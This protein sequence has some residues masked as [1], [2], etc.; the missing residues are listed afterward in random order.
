MLFD[1][2]YILNITIILILIF[3]SPTY[4][5]HKS[6]ENDKTI[7]YIKNKL[8][9]KENKKIISELDSIYKNRKDGYI[10]Y[11]A[12]LLKGRIE[13]EQG[14]VESFYKSLIETERYAVLNDDYL[15]LATLYN[16]LAREYHLV[17]FKKE[18]DKYIELTLENVQKLP[19]DDDNRIIIE[20]GILLTKAASY[21]NEKKYSE[22]LKIYDQVFKVANRLKGTNIKVLALSDVYYSKANVYLELD[23]YQ[24]ALNNFDQSLLIIDSLK[25]TYQYKKN[26]LGY[27]NLKF[28]TK[29]YNAAFSYLQLVD[30]ND[31]QDVNLKTILYTI[32]EKFYTEINNLEKAYEYNKKLDT[33]KSKLSEVSIVSIDGFQKYK[34]EENQKFEKGVQLQ[35]TRALTLISILILI[36]CISIIIIYRKR[37]VLF[38][39]SQKILN[40]ISEGKT[41]TEISVHQVT[42][43]YKTKEAI[44]DKLKYFESSD[45]YLKKNYLLSN[46]ASDINTNYKY[47]NVVLKEIYDMDFNTY[48]NDLK[49]KYILHL[50]DT[51]EES[52]KYKLSYV[53]SLSGFSSHSKFSNVF[54]NH[55]G[56]TPSEYLK[57][58]PNKM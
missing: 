18:Q 24:E 12:L 33:L 51:D 44:I 5:S 47:I 1:F 29:E 46:L 22:A 31:E 19:K 50:W 13:S 38:E 34:V 48:I 15:L 56:I 14:D 23:K 49:I 11:Y 25:N 8:L 30:E 39:K 16:V 43:S 10:K 35:R 2:K 27:A 9:N 45:L 21:S 58:I 36:I 4:A 28:K 52:R 3:A 32:Y 17:G 57:K 41:N 6:F 40:V 53:A 37:N 26:L 55:T 42:L 7:D 20:H 54:K